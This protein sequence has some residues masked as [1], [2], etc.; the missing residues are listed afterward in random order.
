MTTIDASAKKAVR[1]NALRKL[2]GSA[3]PFAALAVGLMAGTATKVWAVEGAGKDDSNSTTTGINGSTGLDSTVVITNSGVFT[4][5]KE[6]GSN[7]NSYTGSGSNVIKTAVGSAANGDITSGTLTLDGLSGVANL[8]G[9]TIQLD[10]SKLGAGKKEFTLLT[11]KTVSG[12]APGNILGVDLINGDPNATI[13]A[14]AT[15]ADGRVTISLS[16]TGLNKVFATD[17]TLS[18]GEYYQALSGKGKLFIV[19]GVLFGGQSNV[20]TTPATTLSSAIEVRPGATFTVGVTGAQGNGA[21]SLDYGSSLKAGAEGVEVNSA[22]SASTVGDSSN[23]AILDG[24]TEDGRNRTLKLG[25]VVSGPFMVKG[26]VVFSGKGAPTIKANPAGTS[27]VVSSNSKVSFAI[28]GAAGVGTVATPLELMGGATVTGENG[29]GYNSKTRSYVAPSATLLTGPLV[30]SDGTQIV[31]GGKVDETYKTSG[32]LTLKSSKV[33]GNGSLNIDGVVN[34][35]VADKAFLAGNTVSINGAT[36][37]LIYT[38][39]ASALQAVSLSS[40]GTLDLTQLAPTSVDGKN[41]LLLVAYSGATVSTIVVGGTKVAAAAEVKQPVPASAA[42]PGE[43]VRTVKRHLVQTITVTGQYNFDSTTFKFAPVSGGYIAGERLLVAILAPGSSNLGTGPKTKIKGD[44][45]TNFKAGEETIIKGGVANGYNSGT[46]TG[47][48]FTGTLF[49]PDDSTI[50][51][52]RFK[53]TGTSSTTAVNLDAGT[54]STPAV[55]GAGGADEVAPVYGLTVVDANSVNL[56]GKTVALTFVRTTKKDDGTEPAAGTAQFKAGSVLTGSLTANGASPNVTLTNAI[57][58]AAKTAP[59]VL[60]NTV[61]FKSIIR[62]GAVGLKLTGAITGAGSDLYIDQGTVEMGGALTLTETTATVTVTG[63]NLIL[64]SKA[65]SISVSGRMVI[66]ANSTVTYTVANHQSGGT[67]ALAGGTWA[68][69]AGNPA[70]APATGVGA[71]VKLVDGTSSVITSGADLTIKNAVLGSTADGT[72]TALNTGKVTIGSPT[73][74]KT[75]VN[76]KATGNIGTW[77]VEKGATLGSIDAATFSSAAGAVADV[78]LNGGTL[79]FGKDTTA[80][81]TFGTKIFVAAGESSITNASGTGATLAGFRVDLSGALTGTGTLKLTGGTFYVTSFGTF[82]GTLAAQAATNLALSGTT[83]ADLSIALADKATL[84]SS[85]ALTVNG[86]ISLIGV[87]TLDGSTNG[88]T[89]TNLNAAKALNIKGTVTIGGSNTVG[90]DVTVLNGTDNTLALTSNY[91]LGANATGKLTLGEATNTAVQTTSLKDGRAVGSTGQLTVLR[92]VT[93]ATNGKV[94][95]TVVLSGNGLADNAAVTVSGVTIPA[96]LGFTN[97][98]MKL[99]GTYTAGANIKT[100]IK[101][102]V[103]I[104]GKATFTDLAIDYSGANT[105]TLELLSSGNT[106]T[107]FNTY[108]GTGAATAPAAKQVAIVVQPSVGNVIVLPTVASTGV[109]TATTT[110]SPPAAILTINSPAAGAT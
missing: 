51:S 2:L 5:S 39:G 10:V 77:T 23:L 18:S 71:D 29:V 63:A 65:G 7:A 57:I 79:S 46:M 92:N 25:G 33:T 107:S 47:L 19:G 94:G 40:N 70:K 50:G 86:K 48:T 87:A 1:G 67:I 37:T 84:S 68:S 12:L 13:S 101:G 54:L 36:S 73:A 62:G 105:G 109:V 110:K 74:L 15:V 103:T 42:Y 83:A 85:G 81:V 75:L 89:L 88:M 95:R 59:A 20:G 26:V 69:T 52:L 55:S 16:G 3:L 31:S 99:L 91:A 64:S 104:A 14:K 76:L 11:Y 106:A 27:L 108:D 34:F 30:L 8:T 49:V 80:A 78:R 82:A 28:S 44:E 22:I 98:D 100:Q 4:L 24:T 6:F 41:S 21:I 43:P 35:A 93:T 90:G 38:G 66:G 9:T 102:A 17:T 97:N 60:G 72:G 58:L 32:G 61:E 45:E 96:S 56:L 53:V